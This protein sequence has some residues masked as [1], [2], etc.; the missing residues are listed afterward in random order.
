M[1]IKEKSIQ[2]EQVLLSMGDD[3]NAKLAVIESKLATIDEELNEK[4]MQT[5]RS[6]NASYQLLRDSKD[7]N[8]NVRNIMLQKVN[9]LEDYAATAKEYV[10]KAFITEGTTVRTSTNTNNEFIFKIVPT[11]LCKAKAGLVAV[12]SRVAQALLNRRVGDIVQIETVGGKITY[13]VLEFY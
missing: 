8:N 10:P 13:T 9:A 5:D 1:T 4:E 6:E 12:T 3:W 7:T 11:E 2:L